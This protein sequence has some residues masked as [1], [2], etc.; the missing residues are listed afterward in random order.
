MNEWSGGREREIEWSSM[1]E[2]ERERER[3]DKCMNERE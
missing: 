3:E 2:R 1:Q